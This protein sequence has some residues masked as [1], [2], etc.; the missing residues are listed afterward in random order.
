MFF[1]HPLP[2][3]AQNLLGLAGP[4][5]ARRDRGLDDSGRADLRHPPGSALLFPGLMAPTGE[6]PPMPVEH[7]P[8][9]DRTAMMPPRTTSR[10][11]NR[12]HRIA[13]ERTR[14]QRERLG[15]PF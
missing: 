12:A 14:N 2:S 1:G 6:F 7:A 15:A 9:G 10:A 3:F 8:D 5:A 11:K 13:A 4:P